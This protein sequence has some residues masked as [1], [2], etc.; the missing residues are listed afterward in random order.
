[1][2][3]LPPITGIVLII[4]G[5]LALA[6]TRLSALSSSNA[7]LITGLTLI[8]AGIWLHIRHIKHESRY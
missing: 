7:L 6:M 3:K 4:I 5:T 8:V 1:M 2:K